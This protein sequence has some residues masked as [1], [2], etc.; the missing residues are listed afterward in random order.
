M[1]DVLILNVID[2]K[3]H[4]PKIDNLESWTSLF[5]YY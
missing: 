3:F 2:I 4:P 1:C 5:N